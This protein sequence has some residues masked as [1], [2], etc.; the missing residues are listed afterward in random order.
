MADYLLMAGYIA[1]WSGP[2]TFGTS[3]LLFAAALVW[4]VGK[5]W[6]WR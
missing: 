1:L 4:L 2:A 3:Y 6:R 5:L